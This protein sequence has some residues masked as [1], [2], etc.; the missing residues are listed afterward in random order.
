MNYLGGEKKSWQRR[1]KFLYSRTNTC[2]YIAPKLALQPHDHLLLHFLPQ[3]SIY[4]RTITCSY[5]SPPS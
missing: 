4:S 3:V 1:E 2:S 5:R